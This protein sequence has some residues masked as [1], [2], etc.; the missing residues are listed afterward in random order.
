[1]QEDCITTTTFHY[2]DNYIQWGNDT[3]I[4]VSTTFN[5]ISTEIVCDSYWLPDLN[6]SG[7]GG[8]GS[9][10]NSGIAGI[11]KD[12]FG[13]GCKYVI[14]D[15]EVSLDISDF[16]IDAPGDTITPSQYLNCFSNPSS[17][18]TFSLTIYVDQ[19]VPNQDDTWENEGTLL[20]PDI[21]VGHTFISLSMNDNGTI[22]KQNFGFYPSISVNPTNPQVSGAWVDDGGHSFDVSATIN[23][24]ATQFN[25]LTSTIQNLGTPTYNLNTMNCTDVALQICNS[26]GMNLTDT[27][28]SWIGGGG[29]NPGN[30][31]QD[32]RNMNNSTVSVNSNGGNASLSKG[33][34]D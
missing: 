12:C 1:M 13:T 22:V 5:G 18:A 15:A 4:F 29:S 19:P 26:M 23:L 34:C 16:I 20:D 8:S 10:N 24:T 32:L 3:P 14:D 11:Y 17:N 6:T 25:N 2:T 7:G 21:N 33:N 28:G 31:G 9:Y 27:M 30:L